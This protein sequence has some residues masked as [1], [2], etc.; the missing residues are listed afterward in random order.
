MTSNWQIGQ[1]IH[2]IFDSSLFA[3]SCENT[4]SSTKP[5]VHRR[6]EPWLQETCSQIS[7]NFDVFYTCEWTDRTDTLSTILRTPTRG[8]VTT[9]K[10]FC[11]LAYLSCDVRS[12]AFL[13]KFSVCLCT[14]S[15][16]HMSYTIKSTDINCKQLH[17]SIDTDNW[18]TSHNLCDN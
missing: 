9:E 13:K 16:R 15:I 2:V 7:P 3:P 12:N 8:K 5:E 18:I 6:T 1:N 17:S 14:R 10:P 11:C 4:T